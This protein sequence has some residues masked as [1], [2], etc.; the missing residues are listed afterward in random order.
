VADAE[1]GERIDHGVLDRGPCPD[2]SPLADPLC[3]E[4][5]PVGRRMVRGLLDDERRR[6]Q[7]LLNVIM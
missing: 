4:R 2:S 6:G 1:V 7:T 3:P 5:V